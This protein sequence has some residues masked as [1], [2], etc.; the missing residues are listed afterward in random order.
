MKDTMK[1]IAIL[2]LT[3]LFAGSLLALVNELTRDRIAQVQRERKAKAIN[4]VLPV[5]DNVPG[6]AKMVVSHDGADWT[7]FIGRKNES[8]A[9]AAFE[10]VSREGYG[11]NIKLMVGV[12]SDGTVSGLQVLDQKETPGLGANIERDEFRSQFVGLSIEDT[13]WKVR[14]DGGDIDAITAATIS[15]RAVTAAVDTGLKVFL[16]HRD[17]IEKTGTEQ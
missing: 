11:G 8:F 2:T 6:E 1:L 7:F 12:A 10:T 3:C 17:E 13:Q 4:R 16:A 15:S 9:G 5:C 14:K